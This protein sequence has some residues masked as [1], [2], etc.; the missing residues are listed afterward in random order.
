MTETS[1]SQAGGTH[2]GDVGARRATVGEPTDEMSVNV[3]PTRPEALE[4][5]REAQAARTG[6][7]RFVPEPPSP[8]ERIPADDENVRAM[9][10]DLKAMDQDARTAPRSVM[11]EPPPSHAVFQEESM[12]T[13]PTPDPAVTPEERQAREQVQQTREQVGTTVSALAD[14]ADIKQRLQEVTPDKVVEEAKKRP[15]LLIAAAG[16]VAMVV[17]RRLMRRGKK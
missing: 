14:K 17:L 12:S 8:D 4:N 13:G 11:D 15:K 1:G 16:V 9:G 10:D 2:A 5:A 6:E 7:E 3:P